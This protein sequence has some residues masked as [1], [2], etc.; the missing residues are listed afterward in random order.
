MMKKTNEK[1]WRINVK[2]L[3]PQIMLKSYWTLLVIV[4]I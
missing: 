1:K 4:K 3:L 2:F